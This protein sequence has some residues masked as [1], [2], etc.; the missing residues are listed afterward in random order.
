M[1]SSPFTTLQVA[2]ISSYM[3]DFEAEVYKVDPDFTSEKSKAGKL[4]TFKQAKAEEILESP[5]FK[6]KLSEDV[7]MGEW[8][9]VSK[10]KFI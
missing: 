2:H 6:N 4:T 7:N 3:P 10:T 1:P 9:K 8:R 5:L